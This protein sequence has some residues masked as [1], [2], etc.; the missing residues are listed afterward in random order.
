MKR[1]GALVWSKLMTHLTVV[2]PSRS[3]KF[4][5]SRHRK[6]QPLR[7]SWTEIGPSSGPEIKI[8]TI[9]T[10]NSV[11]VAPTRT[12]T[13]SPTFINLHATGGRKHRYQNSR[14]YDPPLSYDI[15]FFQII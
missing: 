13:T 7:Q 12:T 8:I 9:H 2:L 10:K 15:S 1:G 6:L 5:S 14:F 4:S 11:V 3:S